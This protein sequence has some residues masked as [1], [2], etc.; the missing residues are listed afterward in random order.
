MIL[1]LTWG[2]SV[3]LILVYGIFLCFGENPKLGA[4]LIATAFALTGIGAIIL[5]HY[6]VR[7][8]RQ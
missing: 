3:V 2:I 5:Y 4:G 8:N 6:I 7:P 1:L